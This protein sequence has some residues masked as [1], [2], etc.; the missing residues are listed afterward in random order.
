MVVFLKPQEKN[1]LLLPPPGLGFGIPKHPHQFLRGSLSIGTV[2]TAYASLLLL[3][4]YFLNFAKPTARLW[5][6]L[7]LQG[8]GGKS[9]STSPLPPTQFHCLGQHLSN[10]ASRGQTREKLAADIR[11]TRICNTKSP[12][13]ESQV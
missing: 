8:G 13:L 10:P 3:R 2:N 11:L 7:V 5:L 12:H 6:Q 1:L 4:V 9:H